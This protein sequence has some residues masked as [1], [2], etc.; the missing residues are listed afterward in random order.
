MAIY[1]ATLSSLPT[2]VLQSDMAP[3]T[4]STPL[5][6][7]GFKAKAI[8]K[9]MRRRNVFIINCLKGTITARRS[10]GTRLRGKE[11]ESCISPGVNCINHFLRLNGREL[12]PVMAIVM[13]QQF[14]PE[15][16]KSRMQCMHF[17]CLVFAYTLSDTYTLQTPNR[18]NPLH[19]AVKFGDDNSQDKCSLPLTAAS[20]RANC[21]SVLEDIS[22]TI[23]ALVTEKEDVFASNWATQLI[24]RMTILYQFSLQYLQLR[25]TVHSAI[26]MY[27]THNIR[28]IMHSNEEK[29]QQNMYLFFEFPKLK[30][31][32]QHF[33]KPGGLFRQEKLQQNQYNFLEF[34]KLKGHSQNFLNPGGLF[35]FQQEKV[36]QNQYNFWDF[37][38]LKGHSLNFFH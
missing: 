6:P 38:K 7:S 26:A 29:L 11:T 17:A 20:S 27:F 14:T 8:R 13:L 18:D 15:I 34:L 35:R 24:K 21:C 23:V 25:L 33:L 32:S 37:L 19:L 9:N 5:M 4:H 31:H 30:G 16:S 3:I 22:D 36:Q 1:M 28:S 2:R 12:I 10:S